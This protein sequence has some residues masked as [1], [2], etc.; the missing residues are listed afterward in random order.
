MPM[1]TAEY[2]NFNIMQEQKH[3][4]EYVKRQAKQVKR[5]QGVTHMEALNFVAKSLGFANWMDCQRKLKTDDH[6]NQ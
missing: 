2:Q 4:L 1:Y 5:D 3:T 6:K